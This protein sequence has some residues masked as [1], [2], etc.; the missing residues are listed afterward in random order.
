[1]FIYG[2]ADLITEPTEILV[3]VQPLH[4]SGR[5]SLPAIITLLEI[6][7]CTLKRV[8]GNVELASQDIGAP[9]QA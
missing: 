8:Q 9:G 6:L 5:F 7:R 1:M 2:T 4:A 3:A